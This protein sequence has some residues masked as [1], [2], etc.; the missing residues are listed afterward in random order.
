MTYKWCGAVLIIAS[1]GGYGFSMANAYQKREQILKQLIQSLQFMENELRY[2]LTP[3]PDLCRASGDNLSGVLARVFHI[4]ASE[5]NRQ[6]ESDAGS[7]ME[8][9]ICKSPTL[10]SEVKQHLMHLGSFLGRYDL[11]GQL[12]GLRSVRADCEEELHLIQMDKQLR[13]RNYQTL[14]ICAGAAL[15][16][17][18]A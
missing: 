16:I 17:F 3:L 12:E 13:M 5:L 6:T 8:K 9:A 7:C 10:P 15:A 4:L 18:L 14:G 1:C 2:R 11:P